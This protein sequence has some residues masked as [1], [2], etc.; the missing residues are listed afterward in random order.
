MKK[1]Y[2]VSNGCYLSRVDIKRME[3]FLKKNKWLPSGSLQNAD[4]IIFSTCAFSEDREDDAI[5]TIKR[6]EKEKD[7]KA[8][9]VIAGC[10]PIINREKMLKNFHGQYFDPHSLSQLGDIIDAK[11]TGMDEIPSSQPVLTDENTFSGKKEE[12]YCIRIAYGCLS[13]CSFCVVNNVFPKLTSKSR[14]MIIKEFKAGLSKGY[15]NFSLSAEDVSVYGLDIGTN[16]AELLKDLK[17]I[18]GNFTISLYRLNPEGLMKMSSDF[19]DILRSKKIVYLSI[20]INSGSNRIIKL[21]NRK[22]DA[23][24]VKNYIKKIKK[25]FPFLKFNLDIMVGFP[26]ETE[27]DFQ[28]TLRFVSETGP[29]NVQAF[30]FTDRPGAKAKHLGKTISSKTMKRRSMMLYLLLSA[31]K[32]N[33]ILYQLIKMSYL[34]YSSIPLKYFFLTENA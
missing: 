16:L 4:M 17:K 3:L 34:L 26:G 22:Y 31:K 1:Y 12:T 19:M 23:K 7:E 25:A 11:Y 10:L 9:L 20:P 21:M 24:E 32:R 13:R 28:Q 30:W 27:E 29:D 8:K 18:R 15:K 14:E 33:K 6:L 2:M 5:A